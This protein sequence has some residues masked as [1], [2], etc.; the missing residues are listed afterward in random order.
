MSFTAG[1]TVVGLAGSTTAETKMDNASSATAV[2]ARPRTPGVRAGAATIALSLSVDLGANTDGRVGTAAASGADDDGGRAGEVVVITR[3]RCVVLVTL[4][5]DGGAEAAGRLSTPVGLDTN[6][7][8]RA[9]VLRDLRFP[10]D[11]GAVASEDAE[12]AFPVG[13][14]FGD[15]R[16]VC[17][18]SGSAE[19]SGQLA[20]IAAPTPKATASPPTRPTNL[21]VLNSSTTSLSRTTCATTCPAIR[22]L[23]IACVESI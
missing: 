2:R 4:V 13:G 9:N 11:D 6:R 19:A 8:P 20:K 7:S 22:L 12:V 14:A 10:G 5:V 21:E 16:M 3:T 18:V 15:E 23:E 17:G 1:V